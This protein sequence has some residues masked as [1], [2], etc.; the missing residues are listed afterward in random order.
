MW[1]LVMC[2]GNWH[3]RYTGSSAGGPEYNWDAGN[4]STGTSTS[5]RLVLH[6]CIWAVWQHHWATGQSVQLWILLPNKWIRSVAELDR[7]I[8]RIDTIY[9]FIHFFN[10]NKRQ[11]AFT[12]TDGDKVVY[13]Y[14]SH[15]IMWFSNSTSNWHQSGDQ[16]MR[17]VIV[18][19]VIM[20]GWG[21]SALWCCVLYGGRS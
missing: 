11:H 10:S 12:V 18:S 15:D 21:C 4:H 6:G 17:E 20:K 19:C 5:G 7:F 8:C 14:C 1:W 16:C 3:S 13:S 9:S 2:S